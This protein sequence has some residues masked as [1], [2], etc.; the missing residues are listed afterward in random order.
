MIDTGRG[1]RC[2]G[3]R[4]QRGWEKMG[5]REMSGV[6]FYGFGERSEEERGWKGKEIG[7]GVN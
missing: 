6:G 1:I 3:G 2:C 7:N 4:A 5:G